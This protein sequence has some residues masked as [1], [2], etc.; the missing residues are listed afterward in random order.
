MVRG[1]T[2][3]LLSLATPAWAVDMPDS[4][5]RFVPTSWSSAVEYG[6]EPVSDWVLSIGGDELVQLVQQ[7]SRV[8]GV[9]N[10]QSQVDQAQGQ[11]LQAS[12]GWLPR[13]SGSASWQTGTPTG[14]LAA[15]SDTKSMD[16]YSLSANLTVPLTP[17][18]A[19][20]DQRAARASRLGAEASLIDSRATAAL[21]LTS[22]FLDVVQARQNLGVVTQQLEVEREL[23]AVAEARYAAAEVSGVDVLQQRQQLAST[24][25]D[26]P[27]AE[28]QV[29]RSERALVA[30]L[31][32]PSGEP[33][34]VTLAELPEPVLSPLPSPAELLA[35]E[36]G[37]QAALRDWEAARSQTRSARGGLLPELSLTGGAGVR[38]TEIIDTELTPT[39]S[40]GLQATVP[41][42][43]GGTTIGRMQET[44]AR[45]DQAL[46]TL[47]QEV[48]EVVRGVEDALALWRQTSQVRSAAKEAEALALDALQAAQAGYAA[49][50]S[51]YNSV[52]TSTQRVR[53]ARQTALQ[54]QRDH[55]DAAL[56]MVSLTR[57]AWAEETG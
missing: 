45:R 40:L 43:D 22:A 46:V 16:Q 27:A 6:Q 30:L 32:L 33:A 35:R 24:Q 4:A 42:F 34:P 14:A 26:L 25:A 21:D 9:A 7:S 10:A 20:P 44:S 51:T 54:A 23:L 1:C 28:A 39:W 19:I 49:G 17:W 36:P 57:A 8:S 5:K 11:S 52:L 18:T 55:L 3:L 12:A 2:L 48:V 38:Y 15:V 53:T 37:V 29:G 47:E 13:V 56:A 50:T 41:L 31:R